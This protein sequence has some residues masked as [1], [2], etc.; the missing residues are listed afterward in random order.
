MRSTLLKVAG[1]AA[2]V[3]VVASCD[4]RLPSQIGLS[5]N[6]SS[7][8]GTKPSVTIDTPVVN[9][10]ANIGDSILVVVHLHASRGLAG[11]QLSGLTFTGSAELGTLQQSVRYTAVTAPAS[12]GFRAGLKDTTIRRYLQPANLA[13]TTADS[14]IIK[15]VVIDSAGGRD[16]VTRRIDL[17]SGPRVSIVAPTT[18]DSTPAGIGLTVTAKASDPDGITRITI[19]VAG[20]ASWPTKLDT[21][22]VILVSGAPREVSREAVARIPI[23]APVRSRVTVTATAVSVAGHLGSSGTTIVYVRNANAAQPLVTQ[24]VGTRSELSDS[25]TITARGDGIASVGYVARDSAGTVVA[26]DSI[27]LTQPLAG[28]SVRNVSLSKLPFSIQ[29]KRVYI[30]GFAVDQAGRIGYAVRPSQLTPAANLDV[31]AGDSTLVVYGHTYALPDARN[32]IVGDVVWDAPRQNVVLSNMNYNRLEVFHSQTKTFESNGVAVGSLPW[33]LFISNDPNVL[34]VANSG[35]TNLSRVSLSNLS[36]LNDQRIRTRGT[37]L[38]VVSETRDPLSAKLTESVG[39]PVIYSDRPQYLGQLADGRVFYST[40]PTPEAPLGTIRYLDPTQQYADSKPIIIFKT[41]TNDNTS[42]VVMNAD[43]VFARSGAATNTSDEIVIYD[44]APGTNLPS[45]SVRTALGLDAA[46]AQLKAINGS[47]VTYVTGLDITDAGV[48]DT[49][50][51][52]VSGDRQ[53]LAFGE[54]H[55][56]NAGLV[57]MANASG[58]FSPPITQKDLTDNASEHINGLALDSVGLTVAAHGTQSFFASA[59]V[60]FHLRLQGKFDN[61]VSGQ[62]IA[63]HPQAKANAGDIQRTAYVASN[64]QSVDVV[65]IF[66]YLSRGHLPL[67]TNL[68]GPLRAVLP[69]TADPPDV[70]LKLIGVSKDGLVIIDLRSSDIKPSP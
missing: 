7:G 1:L 66:H 52:A 11:V 14:L 27:L 20:E 64:N 2:A 48:T 55:T 22:M 4:T 30:T 34:L 40:R 33:G 29:G 16:S 50:Y 10:L 5:S 21:S 32:G 24:V 39:A 56:A 63:F 68:Y 65:D 67:K 61:G 31:A 59:D 3:V 25:V 38:F 15:A 51:V 46:I 44:H 41:T 49:T 70:I 17:I 28:N 9:A 12:G 60:P 42:H 13:D 18:G 36:E 57:F 53:W 58:F 69:G 23:N 45:D 6:P 37:Y 35:G 19:R 54:G 47:D 26:R 8:G 43:S 62:G